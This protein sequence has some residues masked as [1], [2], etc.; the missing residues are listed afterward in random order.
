MRHAAC[1]AYFVTKPFEQ[2]FVAAGFLGQEFQRDGL[3][4]GEI[5][6]AVDF[7][8]SALSQKGDDAVAAGEQASGEKAA[9]TQRECGGA[10]RPRRQGRGRARRAGR[11]RIGKFHRRPVVRADGSAAGRTESHRDGEIGAAGGT[12]SHRLLPD[13]VLEPPSW[14]KPTGG[15]LP[16]ANRTVRW[17]HTSGSSGG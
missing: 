11:R 3:A 5:V 8:N 12:G 2:A 9:F 10:R 13:S 6:G 1:N 15:E 16:L 4:E 14:G 17:Y 7:A